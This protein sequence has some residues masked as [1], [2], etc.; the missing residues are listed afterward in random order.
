[1]ER[2]TAFSSE[3]ISGLKVIHVTRVVTT[4]IALTMGHSNIRA[5]S[6]ML[7][8]DTEPKMEDTTTHAHSYNETPHD[9]QT[10]N[11]QEREHARPMTAGLIRSTMRS[12]GCGLDGVILCS[13]YFA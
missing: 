4:M 1:M 11:R 13:K 9:I 6:H 5:V 12:I 3:I 8:V 2:N 7:A 10:R